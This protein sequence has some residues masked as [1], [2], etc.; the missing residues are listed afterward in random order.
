VLWDATREPATTPSARVELVPQL[1]YNATNL[2]ALRISVLLLVV[3]KKVLAY[4][5]I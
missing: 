5:K 2:A 3:D 1:V 4:C